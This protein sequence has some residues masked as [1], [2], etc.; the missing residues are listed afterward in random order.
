MSALKRVVSLILFICILLPLA[1]C[2]GGNNRIYVALDSMPKTLD[3]QT[4]ESDSELL[5]ARNI[6]EG[7]TR[8]DKDGKIVLAAAKSY[9]Y[10]S[11]TY[12]FTLRDGLRWS[13]GEEITAEDFVYGIKRA[14][15]PETEAPFARLLYSIKGA[16]G[17]HTG[18]ANAKSLGISAPDS[19]TVKITLTKD[20][21]DFL[22]T[23]SMP[24]SMPCKEEFFKNSIG[25]YGLEKE[26]VL[27]SGSYYL[28]RWNKAEN[29]IRLYVNEEY[30]GAFKP[31]NGGV[32]IAKDKEKTVPEK[33]IS[34]DS[35]MALLNAK[36]LPDIKGGD[37]KTESVQNICWVLSLGG[38][39]T[40]GIKKALCLCFSYD[41]YSGD[42]PD[43][44]AAARS[45]LPEI[46]SDNLTGDDARLQFAYDPEGARKIFSQEIKE[47]KNKK[48]PQ[49][50]LLYTDSDSM[51][52]AITKIVGNWQKCLSAFINIKATDKSLDE[53]IKSHS[54]SL[55]VLPVRADSTVG[56]YLYKF[57]ASYKGDIYSSDK[58]LVGKNNL[59]PVAYENTYFGY[60]KNISGVYMSNTGGYIDFSYVIKE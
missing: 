12:T 31:R 2:G 41:I 51:R 8:R 9:N 47:L 11:L 4:A 53:Q 14:L 60:N 24:V 7:L 28:A 32:F 43:G 35:D 17:V 40:P 6:Y 16:K 25:K 34:G 26:C 48:M 29:G 54:L 50:V 18:K 52:P 19:K 58:F 10:D 3:P 33:L 22:S 59:L 23:L 46:L 57:G 37:I 38:E 56:E 36:H 30:T 1:A 44:F 55:A 39:L 27:S 13:D 45:F 49:T 42:L 15:L 5:V 21:K 20:D